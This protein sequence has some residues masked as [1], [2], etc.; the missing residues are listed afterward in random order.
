MSVQILPSNDEE[1]ELVK[2]QLISY[3]LGFLNVSREEYA[4]QLNFHLEDENKKIIAGINAVLQA[5]STVFVSILWVDAAHQHHHYASELLRHVEVEA[6]KLGGVIIYLDTY[7]FQAK[8]FYLKQG[9]EQFAVLED[10][11]TPGHLTYF[12]KKAL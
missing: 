10:V 1:K 3:N 11:P 6:K 7:D 2:E 9:Y 8:G 4:I 5:K 12:M